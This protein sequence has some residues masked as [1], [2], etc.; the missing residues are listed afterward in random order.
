MEVRM[1]LPNG[2]GAIVEMEKLRDYCLSAEH[3]RGRH[4]ARVFLSALGMTAAASEELRSAL[5]VA[6]KEEDAIRGV[7][8]LYGTRY[9]IDF[10]IKWK[11][12]SAWVRSSWILRSD[13]T[14]P[15]FVTCYVLR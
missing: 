7:S 3:P 5:L 2:D 15:R 13:E 9:V 6:A 12:R 4:K 10:Q 11:E 1:K 8:D 14:T